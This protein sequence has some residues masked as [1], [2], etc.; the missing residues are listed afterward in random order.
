[1]KVL[2]AAGIADNAE[3]MLFAIDGHVRNWTRQGAKESEMLISYKENEA[4]F[5]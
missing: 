1:M 2:R 3:K 4:Y 5:E